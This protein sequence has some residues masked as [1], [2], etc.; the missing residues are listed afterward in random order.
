VI[1][2]SVV[3]SE[4]IGSQIKLAKACFER[5]GEHTRA[6]DSSSARVRLAERRRR[7]AGSDG[8]QAARTV[9]RPVIGIRIAFAKP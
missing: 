2:E 7:L 3:G 5:D 8:D 6:A 1:L 9:Q 4:Q